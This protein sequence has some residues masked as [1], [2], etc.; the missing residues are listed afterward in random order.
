M[1]QGDSIRLPHFYFE[2]IPE[3]IDQIGEYWID[4][5]NGLI[6]FLRNKD[7]SG[8]IL[9]SLETPMIELKNT[10]NITFEDHKLSFDRNHGIVINKCQKITVNRCQLSN[11]SKGGIDASGKSI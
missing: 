1:C 9:T 10:S 4:R 3:E 11:F 5:N 7:L 2:N 6:Y 8:F